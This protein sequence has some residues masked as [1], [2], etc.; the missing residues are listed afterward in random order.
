M[1]DS[2]TTSKIWKNI[3]R[4]I[5]QGV[6]IGAFA[7]A[8]FAAGFLYRDRAVQTP[9]SPASFELVN[10]A[11]TLM[12]T[13]F[14][15]DL[16]EESARIHGAT[17]G[18]AASFND[19]YTFFIE[20]QAAKI[21]STNLAGR[22]GGIGAELR[23]DEQGQIV[24]SRVYRDSPAEKAGVQDND[25]VLV[26][27]NTPVDESA[28]NMDQAL[29]AIRGEIGTPVVLTI[30]RGERTIEIEVIRAEILIPSV[31][32]QLTEADPQVGYIQIVRFTERSPDEVKQAV[33]ELKEQG[34]TAYIIDLR[35]NGGG[36]VDSAVKV[37]GVFLD[38]GVILYERNRSSDEKVFNAPRGGI[39]TEDPLVVLA[40]A[41]TASASEI[42]A[43]AFQDRQ[44]ATIIGQK[45]FGKGSVQLIL[46]LSD[47]SSLHVT[48]AEWYT[49]DH[50]RIEKE[51]LTPDITT[52]PIEGFDAELIAAI[53]FLDSEHL[54]MSN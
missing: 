42:L 30:Q 50:H 37:A 51:G 29:A 21:D 31:F 20:P 22:F 43:G 26:I 9:P 27:D 25:I 18:L 44:R 46:A 8:A 45:T 36:L 17:Q 23:Q 5:M 38:G 39:A 49:P 54:A 11:D 34:A 33:Q 47:G 32:W 14:L 16:P 19:P 13:H 3:V 15:Y 41:N 24:I 1:E 40:N 10:E 6:A 4:A 28:P 7:G 35:N 52:Q 48:S 53:E 12:A 2:K